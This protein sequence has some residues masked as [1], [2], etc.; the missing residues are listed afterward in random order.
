MAAYKKAQDL[1][2]KDILLQNMSFRRDA[3]VEALLED[4]ALHDPSPKLRKAAFSS[5]TTTANPLAEKGKLDPHLESVLVKGLADSN[6]EVIGIIVPVLAG[7]T[8]KGTLDAAKTR[9]NLIKDDPEKA[10]YLRNIL[11]RP[12]VPFYYH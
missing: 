1:Q 12:R 4:V 9:V 8:N 3:A 2:V 10:A 11:D 7:S 5:L 6:L